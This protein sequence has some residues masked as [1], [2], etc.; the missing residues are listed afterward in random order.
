[1][2]LFENY[3]KNFLESVIIVDTESTSDKPE[4]CEIIELAVGTYNLGDWSTI[5]SHFKPNIPIPAASA[6]KH[7]ITDLMVKDCPSF[8]SSYSSF[9]SIA[10]AARYIVAHNSDYDR[11]AIVKNYENAGI[12]VH[13]IISNPDR[14]ICTL[15]LARNIFTGDLELP[16]YRLGYLWFY[17]EL[18][19]NCTRD[20]IPHRADSD[21]YM[22]GKLLESLVKYGIE[23]GKIDQHK[24]IG[25]QL[26]HL[27][28]FKIDITKWPLG[29][30]K[31]AELVDVPKDYI[32]WALKNLDMLQVGS[33]KF[34]QEFYDAVQ[35]VIT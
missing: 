29:K 17:L 31:G 3:M 11:V 16:A 23:L 14:W 6:E 18:Y 30:H 1:M 2:H 22:A 27:S 33:P 19:H 8:S 24:D 26:V 9:S 13:D 20:I 35:K 25:P 5:S 15:N 4:E 28:K 34:N 21:I 7:F 32:R 12:D 10:G